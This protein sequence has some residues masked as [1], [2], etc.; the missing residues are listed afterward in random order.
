MNWIWCLSQGYEDLDRI[1]NSEFIHMFIALQ[2]W[3]NIHLCLFDDLF[4][5]G[6][7]KEICRV[8]R[9]ILHKCKTA[10]RES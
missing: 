7:H 3:Q 8:I 5:K 6:I 4:V 9:S 2:L 1:L 10:E